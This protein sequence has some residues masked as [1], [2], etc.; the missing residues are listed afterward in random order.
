M[1]ASTIAPQT[2]ALSAEIFRPDATTG[3]PQE[4]DLTHRRPRP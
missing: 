2:P 1:L 4:A 3:A